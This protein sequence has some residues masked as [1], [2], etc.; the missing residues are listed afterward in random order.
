MRK[1]NTKYKKKPNNQPSVK[2]DEEKSRTAGAEP[3]RSPPGYEGEINQGGSKK[4]GGK[5]TRAVAGV[6]A[7][8]TGMIR[9]GAPEGLKGTAAPRA[10][11]DGSPQRSPQAPPPRA[12]PNGR[13]CA[14]APDRLSPH[15]ACAAS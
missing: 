13:R 4:K 7:G 15:C 3:L 11:H 14:R 5:S 9:R 10:P 8:G 1:K 2:P 12:R 6:E